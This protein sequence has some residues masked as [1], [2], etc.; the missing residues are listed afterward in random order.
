MDNYSIS[1]NFSLLSK[2]MDIHGENS[3]KAKSFASAAFTIEKLPTPLKDTP[4]DEIFRIKGIGEST[5][6]NILEMLDTQQCSLLNHYIEITPAG[7][8]E[9]MKIKGLGPKK[10]ATIWKELEIESMGELLYACNENR[11]MLLKGFGAKTQESVRQNIEF[12][13]SNRH[14]FLFAEVAATGQEL[15]KQLQQLLAPAAVSLTGAFRRHSIIIDEIELLIAAPVDVV[16]QQLAALPGFSLTTA[17]ADNLVWQ[18]NEKLKVITHSCTA[19]SFAATLFTTTGS[20]AFIDKFNAA[21]GAAFLHNA[22]SEDAIFSAAGMDYIPP[23]L[24]EGINELTLARNHQLPETI[25]ASDIKGIIH[26]HSNWSDGE[27]SLEEMATA[28]KAQGFEYLVISDHSRS[29]FYANGL[30]IERILAQHA[31]IDELNKK[32]APFR[33]FKSIE[34][35]ILNDGSLDYPDEILAKFD[36]VI[37]SVHSNLKMT[38]EKAMARLL[39]AIENPYTT[40]LGH[41]TG[42]LLLSRNGYPVDHKA[43]IDACA[44]HN[45]VIELNA[46]PRRLDIDWTWLHYALEKKVLISIDPDAHSIHG[47]Q[48]IR[49]GTLAAQKGGITKT[50]NLSSYT[51]DMLNNYL[52]QRKQQKNILP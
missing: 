32:L 33:I 37:A 7:I 30:H 18:L 28:A 39:K 12:Y 16:Q 23:F 4:R 51:V 43:I 24:R 25:V 13:L 48:D 41:M 10:I 19:D 9:I 3:F 50:N 36:L 46:H 21:G 15:E 42:R 17:N 31:E 20:P 44:A 52:L 1:D 6:K 2:L 5:G 38:E 27:S 8:L 40:I 47:F 45:V 11:L 22:T 34:S 49:Y 29:A 35:D 26:S 14:R